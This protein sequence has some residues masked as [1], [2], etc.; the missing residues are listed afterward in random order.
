[1]AHHIPPPPF[2]P[3]P[4]PPIIP[5]SGAG[6]ETTFALIKSHMLRNGMEMLV[7]AK[8]LEADIT[9]LAMRRTSLNGDQINAL[10]GVHAKRLYWPALVASVDGPVIPMVLMGRDVQARWRDMLGATN[11]M[12]AEPGTLRASYGSRKVIADNVAHGS[13]SRLTAS[14]EI[15]LFFPRQ[16][17]LINGG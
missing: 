12:M 7:I 3:T 16:A 15:G 17:T 11:S 10:Y 8:I 9:I 1:M 14:Y 4:T 2:S 5:T 13:D 6:A